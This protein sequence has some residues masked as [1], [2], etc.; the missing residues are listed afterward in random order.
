M[1]RKNGGQRLGQAQRVWLAMTAAQDGHYLN[2]S[3]PNLYFFIHHF[4]V[5]PHFH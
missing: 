5:N 4:L 2:I 1:K 3:I